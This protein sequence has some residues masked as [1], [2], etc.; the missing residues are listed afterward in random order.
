MHSPSV[1]IAGLLLAATALTCAQA[2]AGQSGYKPCT[3]V[4]AAE[5]EALSGQKVTKTGEQDIP[6]K[7]DANHDHD[8]VISIC[9]QSFSATQGLSLTVSTAPTTPEGKAQGEAAAKKAEEML[10]KQGAKVEAKK[11]GNTTCSTMILQ[12]AMAT[13]SGTNC[14]AEKGQLFF[15]V[16]VTAGTK[17]LVPMD[18]VHELA[19][20]I[21]SRLP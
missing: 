15:S 3:M 14:G 7:K 5:A 1:R 20:K 2:R 13:F 9:T 21:L 6:Y 11:Y 18:Q 8:G 4:S 12:G 16:S 17:G 10:K 19:E